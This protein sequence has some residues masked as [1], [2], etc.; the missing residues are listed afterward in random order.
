[1]N[2]F[3]V[4]W[5]YR[6]TIVCCALLLAVPLLYAG[7][8]GKISG[9]I[10][11]SATGEPL[12]G[13]NVIL[14]GTTLGAAADAD[15]HFYVLNVPPGAYTVRATMI[16]YEALRQTDVRVSVDHTTPVDF[17]LK[18]SV[19][20]GEVVTV[21][22]EREVVRMDQS[23][24]EISATGQDV[25]QSVAIRDVTQ[26]VNQQVGVAVNDGRLEIRGGTADQAQFM[27]DG[28]AVVDNRRNE[29]LMMVNLSAIDELNVIK[30]GFN[31]EYGNV[32]S[33]LVNVITK[34]GSPDRYNSTVD[35][36][37]TP[38]RYKHRGDAV[39][40]P[41]NY[42][43]RPYLDP[44]VAFVGTHSGASPWSEE[45][46]AQYAQFRGWNA[47]SADL[48][49]DADANN[50]MTPEQLR[51][52]FLFRHAAEG[53]G[54]LGQNE[55]TYGDKPDWYID[56]SLSGPVPGIGPALGDLTFF[57]THKTDKQLF[58]LPLYRDYFQDHNTQLKLTSRLSENMKLS[59][60]GIRNEINTV[61][62]PGGY[63]GPYRSGSAVLFE[64]EGWLFEH[65]Y[66]VGNRVPYDINR[67][68]V[69][70][71][72]DHVV[73]SNTFYSLRVSGV[74]VED[75][76]NRFVR[77]RD[78][79]TIATIGN[80]AL[81]EAPYGYVPDAF[82]RM[83]DNQIW[84]DGSAHAYN[85]TVAKTLNLSLDITSQMNRFNQV[86]AGFTLIYDDLD[87][88]EA[89]VRDDLPSQN[90]ERIWHQKP[91]RFGAFIQDKLE[92]QGMIANLG[93]RVDHNSPNAEWYLTD[94]PYSEFFRARYRGNFAE[95]APTVPADGQTKLSPRLGISHPISDVSKLY[96]NYGH[97]YSL[98]VSSTMY[99]IDYGNPGSGIARLGNPE[100][101]IP[102]TVA[103][104]LGYEH[105]I[106]DTW[107]VQVS[108]YYR[109][110]SNQTG[111]VTYINTDGGV[112]YTTTQSNN[113]EDIR[114]F[115]IQVRKRY[116]QWVTGWLNYDYRVESSGFFGRRTY[117]ENPNDQAR[118]GL[119]DLDNPDSDEFYEKP[120][121][122]PL[123][124]AQLLFHSPGDLG[125]MLGDWQLGLLF[126]YQAGEYYTWDP[127]QTRKLV[128][129]IQWAP[130]YNLDLRLS[131]FVNFKGFD[132]TFF[133]DI[134]NIFDIERIHIQGFSDGPGSG[135]RD[136]ST[137][138]RLYLESLHLPMYEGAEYQAAG[139]TPGDDQ[140]GDK[141]SSD[142]DYINMPNRG[143]LTYLN[144]GPR[145]IEFGVRLGL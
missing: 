72:L 55:I 138:Y 42:Y 67:Y 120:L 116:G 71:A 106:G 96:F 39:T 13:A 21:V 16:G 89:H 10:L 11:D 137:D 4:K 140:P 64:D 27:V 101:E 18:S 113:F 5:L 53:S 121:A 51:D 118:Q 82:I 78:P 102:K 68:L 12:P 32:R 17:G 145:Y 25:V 93:L 30:G 20:E 70:M 46:R 86:K 115:E 85:A 107:H 19:I 81:D 90:S 34:S 139:Y 134:Y 133:A 40:S 141:K 48:L 7:T 77:L 45:M 87:V 2:E 112:N 26:F 143:F 125:Q 54:A 62:G 144:P 23:A 33:G 59:V 50:D 35:F 105:E 103:Y 37:F 56:G 76:A 110:I 28:L 9:T 130:F 111:N 38:E 119:I 91:Y 66:Y 84:Q 73:N 92:F 100:A 142:K 44:D 14:E 1:M 80:V 58:A 99:Q 63:S 128:N 104:E 43:L 57:V 15:G 131:K 52:V 136:G 65:L 8:T 94:E 109:D 49:A 123:A 60:E 22:S 74:Q 117:Y 36:R 3:I 114:G 69:G 79:S 124:R 75:D 31:A 126:S 83:E 88:D 47:I 135:Q 132:M 122:R 97:F 108:G 98:P 95:V 129:N 29:P 6:C 61:S 24:S 41:F 127:L